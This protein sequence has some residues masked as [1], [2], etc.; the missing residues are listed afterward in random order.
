MFSKSMLESLYIPDEKSARRPASSPDSAIASEIRKNAADTV[1]I[2]SADLSG[3][4]SQEQSDSS[5]RNR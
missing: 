2:D 3:S 1:R 5:K 4:G